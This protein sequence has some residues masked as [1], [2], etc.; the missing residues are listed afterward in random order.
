VNIQEEA[1]IGEGCNICDSCFLEKGVVVG[2]HVT[3]KNGVSVFQ[4]VTLEDDVFIGAN[5]AFINDRYPRSHRE[6]NWVLET[7]T[8]KKGATI[9]TNATVLCGLEIGEY[10]FIGAGSVVIRNVPA[11]TLVVG[12]P[13]KTVGFVCRCGRKLTGDLTC[14]CQLSYEFHDGQVRLRTT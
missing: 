3:V 2:S 11:H 12:N 1:V 6:D 5:V 9:G 4:G 8:V 7:T 10:A 14:R 13:A